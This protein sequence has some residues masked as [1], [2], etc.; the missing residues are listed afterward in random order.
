M[1]VLDTV[2]GCLDALSHENGKWNVNSATVQYSDVQNSFEKSEL[3]RL[4]K[5][6]TATDLERFVYSQQI[7]PTHSC[8]EANQQTRSGKK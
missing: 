5:E 6:K 8:A 2:T 3:A 7:P 1:F 4:E